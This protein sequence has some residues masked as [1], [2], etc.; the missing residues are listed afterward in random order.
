M[1]PALM[2]HRVY[3]KKE[4]TINKSK[5]II[6]RNSGKCYGRKRTGYPILE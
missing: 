4:I 2:E 3:L 6:I 1:A 5:I